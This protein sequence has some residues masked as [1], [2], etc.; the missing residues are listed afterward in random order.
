MEKT[1]RW[2]KLMDDFF[3]SK[4]IKL[5][6]KMEDGDSLVLIYLKMQLHSMK[7]DGR[8]Y[9]TGLGG[10]FT[11]ELALDLDED[12]NLVV[13]TVDFLLRAGLMV[14]ENDTTYFLPYVEECTGREDN[15]TERT[16]R[17]R[18]RKKETDNL[19]V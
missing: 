4:R 19:D 7:D 9:Y 11:E 18:E 8:I 10:T 2:M 6:R 13:R 16:R 12:D 17:Y 5:L 15:S 14:Q 1:Y 3:S